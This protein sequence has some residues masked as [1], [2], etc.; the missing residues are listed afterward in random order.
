[1]TLCTVSSSSAFKLSR[2]GF[3]TLEQSQLQC[4]GHSHRVFEYQFEHGLLD[5]VS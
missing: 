3:V 5:L 2:G 4:T 1:M